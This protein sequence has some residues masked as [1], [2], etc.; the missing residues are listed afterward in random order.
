LQTFSL[1]I[2]KRSCLIE[3]SVFP[4]LFLQDIRHF[5]KNLVMASCVSS[6][7]KCGITWWHDMA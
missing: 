7:G 2:N 1:P 3:R 4:S 5:I 6:M